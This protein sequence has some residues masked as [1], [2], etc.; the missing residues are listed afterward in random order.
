MRAFVGLFTTSE[1]ARRY[2]ERLIAGGQVTEFLVR[3]A[4]LSQQ[5]TRPRRVGQVDTQSSNNAAPVNSKTSIESIPP[6]NEKVIAQAT[7]RGELR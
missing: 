4:E 6:S 1:S 7:K 5:A 3:R 2:G